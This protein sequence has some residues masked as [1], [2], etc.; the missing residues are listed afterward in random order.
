MVEQ[1]NVC[2][3]AESK[4]IDLFLSESLPDYIAKCFLDVKPIY[5]MM[6]FCKEC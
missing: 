4:D 1:K 2:L 3:L 6:M 5:D